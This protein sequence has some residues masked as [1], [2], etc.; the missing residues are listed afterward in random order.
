[1]RDVW[2]KL[3][4]Q[5]INTV[6]ANVSWDAIEPVEGC[7][8]FTRLDQVI[9]DARRHGLHL[10]LLWFGAFKNGKVLPC[11]SFSAVDDI[12]GMSTYAPSWVKTNAARFPRA[13]LCN[14]NDKARV[15]NALSIFHPEVAR[16]D[17]AAFKKLMQHL[18][19]LDEKHSTIIMVQ[20]ENEVG[21][22]G[23]SR[24]GSQ[25]A[26][27]C[28]DEVVPQQLITA[29]S[30]HWDV[31]HPS[32][33]KN[34]STYRDNQQ[35]AATLSWG[36]L[37]GE[38][39]RT[40]EIFMAYHY[41]LYVESV[42][43]EGK[44][45]YSIPMFTNVWQNYADDDADRSQPILV[46]GGG[47]PGDYPSGGAVI[48]VLDVWQLFAPSLDFIAPDVYLNDYNAVCQ[49]Y[50]HRG[51]A[52]FI[53]EQRRDEYG[54]R[55]IWSAYGT[56]HALCAA[57]FAI[58]TLQ[59]A[60]SP[61]RRHYG[62]LTQVA[63]HIL[64][65]QAGSTSS[66]GFFFDE[67]EQGT[68]SSEPVTASLGNWKLSIQRSFVF[69]KPSPGFGMVIQLNDSRFLLVGE[70]FEVRFASGKE[71]SGYTGILEF[72]EKVYD[73]RTRKLKTGRLL[74][75]DE[76]RSGEAA[77]MPSESPDLGTFPIAITIPARTRIAEC[78]V[79]AI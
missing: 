61:W 41:A 39:S 79:Y 12:Q 11:V 13:M 37:F 75:G 71:A 77:I 62:L 60:D 52:L 47:E 45:E 53:P 59:S 30:D 33:Q 15:S 74:N 43:Q 50:R 42:A 4:E 9:Y 64:A 18:R 48:N 66:V 55:R 2:A 38:N 7:F 1:M 26:N 67:F 10:I 49:K 17:A 56:H 73:V 23:A 21:L 35:H 72:V 32:L 58:D 34:L 36:K 27:K 28:F 69:G 54:A 31:L 29:I 20:V 5:N 65:A 76:T 14:S 19:E 78:Q 8:D 24:D 3:Q 40:D 22:L 44:A 68:R 57:P 70:G 16:A 6:L 63:D 25:A 51:Q 46:G